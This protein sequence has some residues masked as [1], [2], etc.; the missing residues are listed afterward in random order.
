MA[1]KVNKM[2]RPIKNAIQLFIIYALAIAAVA[3]VMNYLDLRDTNPGRY[4]IQ[5]P[6]CQYPTR[7]L[8]T[9]GTCDNSDPA[10]PETMKEDGGDCSSLLQVTAEPQEYIAGLPYGK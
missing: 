2:S 10:C 1:W 5:P 8:N 3:M 4:E 7:Q 9:D 6:N